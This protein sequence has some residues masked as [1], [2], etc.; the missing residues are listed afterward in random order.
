MKLFIFI[1]T[2]V[3]CI[4]TVSCKKNSISGE[5]MISGRWELRKST[6]GIAGTIQYQPGNGTVW[7]FGN[8][9]QYQFNSA[10]GFAQSGTYEIKKANNPGDWMLELQHLAN[11]QTF[12]EKD[13]IRFE[14]NQLIFLPAESCCDIST[15]MYE[16]LP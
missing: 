14:T 5:N 4:V 6:G 13:S 12:T 8:N 3:A 10:N 2:V 11:G 16:R 1:S 15:D 9:N 7:L